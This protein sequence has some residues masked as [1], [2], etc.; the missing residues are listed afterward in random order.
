MRIMTARDANQRFSKILAEVEKGETVVI[1][2]SGRTVAE[3]RPRV[4]DPRDDPAWRERFERMRA[5][6]R[7]TPAT[8]YRV[9][10][11]TPDDKYG[12]GPA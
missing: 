1:T 9:G 8:G 11:I 12:G 7:S 10:K 2:K 4:D 6:M 3:L 5:L